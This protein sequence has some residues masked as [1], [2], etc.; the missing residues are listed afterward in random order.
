MP[1][2]C[3]PILILYHLAMSFSNEERTRPSPSP[4]FPAIT[5]ILPPLP[6]ISSVRLL[7]QVFTHSS[8]SAGPRKGFEFE[9][10]HDDPMRDNEGLA[11]IGDGVLGLVVT[12]L[13]Q[14]RYPRLHVGPT[15]KVRDRIKCGD[16]LAKITLQYGLHKKLRGEGSRLRDVQRV[17]VNVFKAYVGGLFRE[18]GV[19]VVKRWLDPLFEPFVDVAYWAER[20]Y[21][22]SL[23]H[24]APTTSFPTPS[25]PIAPQWMAP[26]PSPPRRAAEGVKQVDVNRRSE[27]TTAQNRPSQR[28][29]Y[30]VAGAYPG[31]TDGPRG[32]HTWRGIGSRDGGRGDADAPDSSYAGRHSGASP[33]Q[34][35][36]ATAELTERNARKRPRS[37]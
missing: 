16:T 6:T 23:E 9:A 19:D 27:A 32:R 28:H 24:T 10:P 29:S 37:K 8:M 4:T 11:H 35:S 25:L 36:P 13:I 17:Q 22:L 1:L 15:S 34:R 18:Q 3:A 2:R 30:A 5:Q 31:Q 33:R 7:R 26:A 12:D 14:G 20:R 21:H